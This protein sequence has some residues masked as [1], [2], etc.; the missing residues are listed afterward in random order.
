LVGQLSNVP[1]FMQRIDIHVLSSAYGE[2]FPNVV[3][4]AMMQGT[5]CVSTDV[6]DAALILGDLGWIV[7][8][9]SPLQLTKALA[10]AIEELISDERAWFRRRE[11]CHSRI[12]R[13]FTLEHMVQRY[14][15]IWSDSVDS[16]T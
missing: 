6:G 16:I 15:S 5:P 8:P 4:E 12:K 1:Q 2:G 9:S 3:A 7:E 10:L 13:N 11:A 14:E